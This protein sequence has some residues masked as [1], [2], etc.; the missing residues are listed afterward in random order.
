MTNAHSK[1]QADEYTQYKTDFESFID[2]CAQRLI[3][4]QNEIISVGGHKNLMSQPGYIAECF[5]VAIT[6][7][8]KQKVCLNRDLVCRAEDD[9]TL[10]VFW[11]NDQKIKKKDMNRRCSCGKWEN[12]KLF[13]KCSRCENIYYCSKECQVADWSEHKQFCKH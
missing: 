3:N 8:D 5:V 10:S 12:A 9:G 7:Q 4:N 6:S 2:D 13:K 11:K 1:H